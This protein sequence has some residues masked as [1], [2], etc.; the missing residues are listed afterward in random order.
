MQFS[1][2]HLLR[3]RK[4]ANWG[5]P[6][7]VGLEL[8]LLVSVYLSGGSR[9][10][11]LGT[12]ILICAGGLGAWIGNTRRQRLLHDVP[13]S[14][15]ASAA[16]GYVELNGR[17]AEFENEA[18]P[19]KLSHTPC[20]W[21]RYL[22]EVQNSDDEWRTEEFGDSE[23]PFRLDDDTG[24]CIIDPSGAEITTTHKNVWVELDHRYTEYLLLPDDD[25]YALG[26]FATRGPDT[27]PQAFK[28]EVAELLATWKT[29]RNQLLQRFDANQDGEIDLQEWDRVR[30]TAEAQ[31]R[32]L[33]AE[34]G[35]APAQ[36]FLSQPQNR[37]PYLLSNLS[38]D[39]LSL[40]YRLWAWGHLTIF[41]AGCGGLAF[42]FLR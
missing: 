42:F 25:L 5:N 26:E 38:H 6:T 40:H 28:R 20:V 9:T 16:Q 31:V 19:A 35:A 15:I 37:R 17:I 13:T 33:L 2:S 10:T 18:L 23:L 21:Y 7:L 24:Y 27:S 3:L 32:S 34:R 4:Q 41:M 30:A 14:R 12:L 8:F 29:D 39:H 1:L 22:I 11:W 36:H